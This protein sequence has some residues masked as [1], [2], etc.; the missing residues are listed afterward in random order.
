M[1]T[2]GTA[3]GP[4]NGHS[5]G[6][7]RVAL[8][9]Q[10]V[11][12]TFPGTR[13][14]IDVS[15]VVNA[16]EVHGLLGGNGSGKSTLI[17]ILAGVYQ[18]DSGGTFA[19]GS[20]TAPADSMTPSLA[21]QYG[22]R[23]VHQN[24]STFG[25]MTIAENMALG[26]VFPTRRGAVNWRELRRVTRVLLDRF[27][28]DARPDDILGELRPAD[29]TMVAIAR[30]LQD[31]EATDRSVER[32]TTDG[33]APLSVLVLDEPTASLPAQEVSILLDAIRRCAARG[34]TIL[35]V[36]HRLDEALSITDRVTVLRD[37]RWVDTRV[38]QE[39]TERDLVHMIVGR[40][41]DDVFAVAEAPETSETI[42]R[43]EGLAG[44]PVK[45]ASFAV[46]RGEIVG[47]AGLLGSGRTE[48]LQMMFGE[49]KREEGSVWLGGDEIA[50]GSPAEAMALGIAYVPEDRDRDAVFPGL[51]VRENLSAADLWRY[52]SHGRIIHS[53]EREAAVQSIARFA[54]RTP[55]DEQV[56]SLLS[57]GNQQKVILGR[58]LRREPRLLLLDEP[59]Q[60]V[61][62]GARADFYRSVREAV[63]SGL[64]V[65]LVSS[66][67]EE[68]ALVADR[69]VVVRDGRTV[70]EVFGN[71]LTRDRLTELA[72][73]TQEDG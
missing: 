70:T 6:D 18:A 26:G 63:D 39:L 56:I 43:V 25:D 49:R 46:R 57:G 45:S 50:Q 21:R 68:L 60:G 3:V 37:G 15:F 30:A 69:V 29:Q 55:S 35:Y 19:I 59:T 10:S 5:Q 31:A 38:T 41:L 8:A 44:G 33:E 23:F 51:T 20:D 61:D 53:R 4:P 73:M 17:K 42:L 11:S 72:Y 52:V 16:G 14:L 34:Q 1:T 32:E 62:V 27:E 54:I 66:D 24:G 36:S 47:I 71:E 58:W 48:M 7:A 64:G 9:V 40:P 28:I 22:L 67:L 13:A 65:V 12:K 2:G